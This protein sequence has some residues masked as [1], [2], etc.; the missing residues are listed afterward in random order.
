MLHLINAP[1][2][3]E[4]VAMQGRQQGGQA[5]IQRKSA[6][7]PA[8]PQRRGLQGR[9]RRQAGITAIQ[10]GCQLIQG[11]LRTIRYVTVS[12]GE[13]VEVCEQG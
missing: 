5:G 4:P 1:P 7:P 9:P 12:S 10:Y 2:A 11:P 6:V 3:P 8:V 13:Y